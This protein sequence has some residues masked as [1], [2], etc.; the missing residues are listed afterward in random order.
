D[1]HV[2][3]VEIDPVDR[4]ARC[5]EAARRGQDLELHQKRTAALGEDVDDIADLAERAVLQEGAARVADLVHAAVA[6]LEHTDLIGGT[7]SIL[8]AAQ[9]PETLMATPLRDR[10][11]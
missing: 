5:A 2:Q 10:D 7:E 9:N 4:S 8:L 1:Q 6:H 11:G 3:P